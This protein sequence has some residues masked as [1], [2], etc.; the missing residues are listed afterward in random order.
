[1][2]VLKKHDPVALY[3][4]YQNI[5]KKT[6]IPGEDNHTKLRWEVREKILGDYTLVTVPK[7]ANTAGVSFKKLT[8][9]LKF[10]RKM[11][12]Y[13]PLTRDC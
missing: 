2:E 6:K 7:S 5:W 4:Y 9:Q 1:M 12:V 11:N 10:G 8:F 13:L 3:H